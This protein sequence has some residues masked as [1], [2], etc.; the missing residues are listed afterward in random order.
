[1]AE[2]V[3]FEWDPK[4]DAANLCKHGVGFV[5]ARTLFGDYSRSRSP[6]QTT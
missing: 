3:A 6:I 4:K 5:E 1:M 2:R